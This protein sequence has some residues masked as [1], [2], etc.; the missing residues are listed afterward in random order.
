L[1]VL[2]E[3]AAWRENE[4][5]RRDLPRRH[6]VPDEVLTDAA[7]RA[8]RSLPALSRVR[9]ALDC[10][11]YG[12]AMLEAIARGLALGGEALPPPVERPDDEVL[13]ARVDFLLS[14]VKGKSLSHTVDPALVASRAELSALVREGSAAGSGDHRLLRGWRGELVGK[15]LLG[16][17]EGQ[18]AVRLGRATGLPELAS[19]HP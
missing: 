13:G 17:L 8:P 6:V 16:L 1:A 2:R 4:A 7:M 5:R 18:D 9:G 15:E 12:V 3:L 19:D 14:Y 11:R 10:E